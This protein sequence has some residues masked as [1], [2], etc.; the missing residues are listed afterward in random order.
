M[1]DGYTMVQSVT[2]ALSETAGDY[3]G[4]ITEIWVDSKLPDNIFKEIPIIKTL[5]FGNTVIKAIKECHEIRQVSQFLLATNSACINKTRREHYV[6]VLNENP[7]QFEKELEYV[8]IV[9]TNYLES[10]KPQMLG[11]I[12]L[13][14]LDG[15]ISWKEFS[16]YASMMNQLI[17]NDVALLKEEHHVRKQSQS[18][19]LLR[20]VALGLMYEQDSPNFPDGD[21]N[22]IKD[23]ETSFTITE[24]GRNFVRIAL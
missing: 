8:M 13:K 3:L 23:D 16:E 21:N 15:E 24:F 2:N 7:K 1:D 9:V 6:K 20:L 17:P 5:A 12:Y 10:E 4:D 11:R 18:R 19:N 14:R 22:T